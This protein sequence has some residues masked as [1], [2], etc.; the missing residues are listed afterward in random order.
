[1]ISREWRVGDARCLEDL[2]YQRDLRGGDVGYQ[3]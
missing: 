3:E 2:G 1:M